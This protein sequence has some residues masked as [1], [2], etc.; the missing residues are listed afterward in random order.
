MEQADGE[1]DEKVQC[2]EI[3][4]GDSGQFN[5]NFNRVT[6]ALDSTYLV[7]SRCREFLRF[8]PSLVRAQ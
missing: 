1:E 7:F 8:V 4:D 2:R 5:R 3:Q 6:L